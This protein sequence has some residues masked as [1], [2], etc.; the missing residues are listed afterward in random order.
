MIE[1][2]KFRGAEYFDAGTVSRDIKR[3]TL[4]SSGV[5]VFSSS[6]SMLIQIVG[7]VVLARLLTPRDFG[8]TAM[9][10]AV[11]LMLQNVGYVGFIEA[12]IHADQIDHRQVSSLFW[13]GMRISITIAVL[14]S[15]VSPLLAK[16][17]HEPRLVA[18]AIAFSVGFVFTALMTEHLAL[19]MRRME[20]GKVMVSEV[21][22]NI[23]SVVIAVAMALWG[24]GYWA[25]VARNLSY[26]ISC[27]AITWI[28]CPWRPSPVFQLTHTKRYIKYALSTYGNFALNSFG[29]NLDKI[30]IGWRWGSQELGNY[31]RAYR[32]FVLPV[33]QMVTPLSTVALATL[34]RL[35]NDPGQYRRY[36]LKSLSII[37]FIGMLVS[38]ILTV[39][40]RDIIVLLLGPQWTKAG[41]VF[42]AFG[43][44]IGITLIYGTQSWLHLSLGRPERYLRWSLGALAAT[45]LMF[46]IGLRFGGLGVAIAYG[47]SYYLLAGPAL[48][49]AGK[50]IGIGLR[51]I[52]HELWR[53]YVAALVSGGLVWLVM[54]KWIILGSHLTGL[55][56]LLRIMAICLS[57][58]ILY[59]LA[60][61]ALYRG[62]QPLKDFL[63]VIKEA[64]PKRRR[65]EEPPFHDP[66]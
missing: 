39:A 5:K 16:F 7:T 62:T 47:L 40:G 42:T 10:T 30:L 12:I 44:S 21:L 61:F 8:L 9:V 55:Y 43:P 50:P 38:A 48:C 56:L 45:A 34:S 36:F 57:C 18:I 46:V 63:M 33:G 51:H 20:F 32:L 49:Y 66:L 19:I 31:D 65:R 2:G 28:Q 60:V 14:F 37:A 6:A 64:I 23:I 1:E 54:A 59:L 13:L 4:R 35:R 58:V 29:R 27:A 22:S 17:Y 25:L 41:Q 26:T 3:K 15:A 24:F 53:Y 11:S 52:W